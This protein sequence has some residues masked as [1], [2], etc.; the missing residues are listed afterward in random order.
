MYKKIKNYK[1]L[2]SKMK[3][4]S[5]WHFNPKI[6]TKGYR[7]FF[8]GNF[9][10]SLMYPN[11]F[12]EKNLLLPKEINVTGKGLINEIKFYLKK[13]IVTSAPAFRFYY[14]WET[15]NYYKS[16]YFT[17]LVS[18][19]ILVEDSYLYFGEDFTSLLTLQSKL[20]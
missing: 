16:K 8:P 19:P 12:E 6:K 13:T 1:S 2:L 9:L 18:L 5:D 3:K 17:I 4:N 20:K 11:N 14:L 7:G 15:K 10:L